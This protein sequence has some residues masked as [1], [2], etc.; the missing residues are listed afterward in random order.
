MRREVK[1]VMVST[2]KTDEMVVRVNAANEVTVVRVRTA[3]EVTVVKVVLRH[4]WKVRESVRFSLPRVVVTR[5]STRVCFQQS[6]NT[7]VES[8]PMPLALVL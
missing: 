8:A 4:A 6:T 2:V 7:N 3:N 1:V 5:A